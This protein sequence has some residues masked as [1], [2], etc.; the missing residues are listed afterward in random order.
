MKYVAPYSFLILCS[1]LSVSCGSQS[2]D[3]NSQLQITQVAQSPV[4]R[5]AIDN[6]WLYASGAWLESLVKTSDDTIV[7]VSESYWTYWDMFDRAKNG[8]LVTKD[9]ISSVTGGWSQATK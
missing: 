3:E 7:N 5:Q 9:G 6:C 8:K 4:K 1:V 2:S